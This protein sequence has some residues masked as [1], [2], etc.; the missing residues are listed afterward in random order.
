[1][2]VA[3]SLA[4][5]RNTKIVSSHLGQLR[6]NV[7]LVAPP[8]E[9]VRHMFD[10]LSKIF[11]ELIT[12]CHPFAERYIPKVKFSVHHN[13]ILCILRDLTGNRTVCTIIR[14]CILSPCQA[15]SFFDPLQFPFLHTKIFQLEARM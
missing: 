13:I 8:H 7:P 5:T 11:I 14:S 6:K 3:E 15:F 12:V 9:G 10:R 2:S 4:L 1:M